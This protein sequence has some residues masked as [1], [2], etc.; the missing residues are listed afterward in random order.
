MLQF[1]GVVGKEHFTIEKCPIRALLVDNL[2]FA[3]TA[4]DQGM[5]S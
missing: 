2:A 5:N 1:H 4:E 3:G